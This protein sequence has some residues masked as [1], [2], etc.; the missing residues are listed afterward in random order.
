[1]SQEPSRKERIKMR[2]IEMSLTDL[3]TKVTKWHRVTDEQKKAR[4]ASV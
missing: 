4:E 3:G 2:Y 1:M